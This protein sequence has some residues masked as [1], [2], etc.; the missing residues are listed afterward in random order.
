[1]EVEPLGMADRPQDLLLLQPQALRLEREGLLHR[2]Q[3]HQLQQVVLDHVPGRAD[4]VVV[5]GPAAD[6]DVLGHRDL[7]VVDEVGVPDRLEQLVG[8]AQ[9]QDVLHRLL[10]EVVV[11]A[12]DRLGRE[13]L[14]HDG[15][16]L[17]RALE[18]VTERLL[19][20]DAAPAVRV[21]LG[22]PVLLELA[23][24]VGE[25]PRRDREVEGVVA[26]RAALAVE[27]LDGVL[28]LG[29]GDV[30]G[31]VAGHEAEALRQLPPD[32]LTKR[33]P[34]V[35]AHGVVHDLGEVLVGPVAAGETGQREARREQPSV[36]QVVDRRHQLLAGEVAGHAEDH[37]PAG[38][39]DLGEPPILRAA[40]RVR[41][42]CARAS[43]SSQQ[44]QQDGYAR[45]R[46][47]EVEPQ[48]RP[49]VVGEHVR[50][51]G[52]LRDDERV[53]SRTGGPGSP[54]RSARSR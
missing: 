10:A 16:E 22:Q 26:G 41:A 44:V 15:V 23:D 33:R 42:R 27:L 38:P 54:P 28:E 29:E 47:V 13:D 43:R 25:E 4:A 1:M 36:G 21:V 18:V 49:A 8:E 9:R 6:A 51:A 34:R 53:R 35:L 48:Y 20:D 31:E 46:V 39:G 19:H 17:L 30:V 2:D 5:A 12:E 32:L 37:H 50:I 7:H 24:D 14:G 11:D 45:H 40:Q 3:R 52:T